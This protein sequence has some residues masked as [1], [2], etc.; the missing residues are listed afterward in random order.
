MCILLCL[1][2]VPI[3]DNDVPLV[4]RVAQV[5]SVLT[6][7]LSFCQL[8]SGTL[9][10]PTMIMNLSFQKQNLLVNFLNYNFAYDMQ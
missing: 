6:D 5:F 8:Q 4:G 1:D 10:S 2:P 3:C 9:K 7:F